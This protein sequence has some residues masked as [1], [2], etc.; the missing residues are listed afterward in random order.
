M[1]T[2]LCPCGVKK[3][4]NECCGA[5]I[6]G[7]QQALT[8]EAL[9]RSRYTAYTE[10]N[11]DYIIRSMKPPAANHFDA[12]SAKEWAL[13]AKW[14]GLQ[15]MKTWTEGTIGFVEF[16]A[17]FSENGKEYQ[18]HE[19]SEFHLIEKTWYYTHGKLPS[20]HAKQHLAKRNAPCPCGSGKKYKKC[21]FK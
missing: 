12:I 4:Y 8:P 1:K 13:H 14:L 5:I 2:Y 15:I 10:A 9:M 16:V 6:S 11:I 17:R 21:C 7:D 20:S 18:L 19:L 3:N